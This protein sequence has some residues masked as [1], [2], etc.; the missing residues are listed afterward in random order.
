MGRKLK[1]SYRLAIWRAYNRQCFYCGRPVEWPELEIDHILP[2]ALATR[3]DK[4]LSLTKRLGLG[5]DF[6]LDN[7]QNCVPTHQNCNRRKLDTVYDLNVLFFYLQEAKK[8]VPAIEKELDQ[9]RNRLKRDDILTS[10]GLALERGLITKD[11]LYDALE[12][13][14]SPPAELTDPLVICFGVNIF[15]LEQSGKLP[16]DAPYYPY[17]CDYLEQELKDKLREIACG[18]FFQPEAS[19]RTGET[20]SVRIA[21]TAL[22]LDEIDRLYGTG[23]E[24]LEIAYYSEIYG[25][26]FFSAEKMH[27]GSG[28]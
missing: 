24:I 27:D 13:Y 15:E 10:I 28:S 11:D 2:Q 23:W 16:P 17:L 18:P 8:R 4:L 26:P 7:L 12:R 19:G 22:N 5:R 6:S 9:L 20:L 25:E 21:F 14:E 3:P 1:E